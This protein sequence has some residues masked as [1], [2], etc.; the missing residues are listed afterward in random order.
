MAEYSRGADAVRVG[1]IG[2]VACSAFLAL[3]AYTTNRT[4]T[5]EHAD[6]FVRFNSAD[7]LRKGDVV[8]LRGVQV[9]EVKGLQF[10]GSGEVVVRT[11]LTEATPLTSEATAQLVAVDIF[12]RQSVVL[13]GGSGLNPLADGDTIP[14]STPV[15]MTGQVEALGEKASLF[16]GDTTRALVQGTLGDLQGTLGGVRGTTEAVTT[17]A[18]QATDLLGAER[19]GVSAA[20]RG[21]AAVTANL[22]SVTDP[23]SIA[24]IRDNL[25]TTTERLVSVS[26]NMDRFVSRLDAVLARFE[27]ADGTAAR[28]L[29][30]PALYHNAVLTLGSLE[31][32]LRDLRENPKRYINLSIF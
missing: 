8:L 2:L 28:L 5:G 30:D 32:L 17:L 19:D 13:N 22:E 29:E 9:G 16:I 21:V 11:R 23:A 7:G 3:F 26:E 6:L 4:L 31:A 1:A 24:R 27:S 18:R 14:G 20:V 25:E 12:G 10:N 15:S